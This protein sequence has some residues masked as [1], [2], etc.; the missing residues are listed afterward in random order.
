MLA[1]DPDRAAMALVLDERLRGE[2]EYNG[3]L[4]RLEALFRD[5][6]QRPP[7]PEG[8]LS[9]LVVGANLPRPNATHRARIA[10][11]RLL[12]QGASFTAFVSEAFW[13]RGLLR[14]TQW[15]RPLPAH[16]KQEVFSQVEE[17]IRWLSSQRRQTT[18]PLLRRLLAEASAPR[19]R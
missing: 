4:D 3:V 2:G 6:N 10:E 15:I 1:Y 5:Y 17:A 19:P 11:L 7:H 16:R 12:T 13:I 8:A 9:L 14:T 18:E